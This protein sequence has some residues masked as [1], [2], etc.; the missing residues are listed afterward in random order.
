MSVET[1]AEGPLQKDAEK[2]ITKAAQAIEK[3]V[4]P[5]QQQND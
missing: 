2:W 1:A 4:V 3:M 5:T